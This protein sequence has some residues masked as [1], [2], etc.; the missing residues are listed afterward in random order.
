MPAHSITRDSGVKLHVLSGGCIRLKK[1]IFT[2]GRDDGKLIDTPVICF[3]IRHPRGNVLFDSGCHPA[4]ATDPA[5]RWGGLARAF[6][7][8]F[9]PDEAIVGE[10]QKIGLTPDDVDLVINSHLHMD[11][12]GGN[13]FFRRAEAVVHTR[14]LEVARDPAMEG[15][16]YFRADWD[17]G[18]PWREIDGQLD[19]FGD[20][21]LVLLPCPGHTPG[22]TIAVV[23]LER[24]GTVLL[25]SDAVI[26]RE[27]L[28]E[29]LVPRNAW[30]TTKL[31][32]GVREIQRWQS[33]GAFVVF[34]HDA[35]QWATLR[36]GAE[37]YD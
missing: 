17:H 29:E 5:G 25:A 6:I 2:P 32:E 37:A 30:D 22:M 16:G 11:H 23:T 9:K 36:K 24:T 27:N 21:R 15:K 4:V 7:P 35:E 19:V 31:I 13:E 8:V 18:R 3:L 20:G 10:L 34:G 12:S 1:G 14:E 33:R 26:V 28:D